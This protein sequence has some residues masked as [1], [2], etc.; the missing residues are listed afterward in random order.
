VRRP[1][2]AAA[3]PFLWAM[4]PV[5]FRA[6]QS[7][8]YF[9][10]ADV[11]IVAAGFVGIVG[12]AY[13]VASTEFGEREEGRLPALCAMLALVWLFGFDPAAR[14]LPHF[15]HHLSYLF[16]GL[17]GA[18][19]SVA[20]VRWLAQRP[21]LLRT[22]SVFLS[23]T[24]ALLVVRFAAAVAMDRRRAEAEVAASP[25]RHALAQ[26]IP[27]PT[28]TRGPLRDVYLIVL[29]EYANADVLSTVFSYDNSPFLDSLRALGFYVPRS[30]GSN[31]AHT[32]LSLPSLLTAAHLVAA[33]REL[34]HGSTDPTLMN[35][36][37]GESRVARF[38]Q[39][40]GYRFI[41][42]PSTWWGST[43]SSPLADSVV[44]VWANDGFTLGRELSRTELRRVLRRETILDYVHRD[45]PWDAEFV[46]RTLAEVAR[47]PSLEPPVFGFVHLLNPHWPY[48]FDRDCRTLR[49]LSGLAPRG[50]YLGQLQCLNGMVL[51]TVGHLIRD[52]KV[53][54]VIILQG[55]HGTA[56]R[57]HW[58][59]SSR[60]AKVENVPASVAWERLGAFGAYY[61]PDGGAAAFGDT[62]T[63]VNVMGN[64]LRRYFGAELP[65]ESNEHYLSVTHDP[66]RFRRVET[67]WLTSGRSEPLSLQPKPRR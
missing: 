25:L 49:R 44:R 1:S 9:T 58:I 32:T 57:G 64:V 38:L 51:A 45:E 3:Y 12:V 19:A 67:A 65:P 35:R 39:V 5:L 61:L 54:P 6:H 21:A 66:F 13:L 22:A 31:Y 24:G 55:D 40:R 42:F 29:D 60:A 56:M 43:Q 20:L 2:T 47:L 15:P 23:L 63:V 11:A 10:L 34:P 4:V 18:V 53:P 7:P 41:L 46:R 62:V 28:G 36:L 50:A 27:A 52:S 37:L 48:V 33:E 59:K 30:V 14:R 26:P 17:A 16:L 8:G